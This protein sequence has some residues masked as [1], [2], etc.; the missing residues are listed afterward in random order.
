MG[1]YM[2]KFLSILSVTI[3]LTTST[4]FV[5]CGLFD[6]GSSKKTYSSSR[7]ID[8]TEDLCESVTCVQGETCVV[9][10]DVAQCG[11]FVSNGCDPVCLDPQTCVLAGGQYSCVTPPPT[12][13][14]PACVNPQTCVFAGGQYSCVTPP[15]GCDQTP[16]VYVAGHRHIGNKDVA[17]YWKNNMAGAHELTLSA[18][19][20]YANS[21]SFDGTNLY[22]GTMSYTAPTG[23]SAA[24]VSSA[25]WKNGA[26]TVL[27]PTYSD[28]SKLFINGT[29]VYAAGYHK[30]TVNS[31]TEV[32]AYWL[33]GSKTDL[34]ISAINIY[35]AANQVYVS[36]SDVYACGNYTSRAGYNVAVYWKN[37]T[38]INIG[39]A[40]ANDIYVSGGDIYIA[41]S[42]SPNS[43]QNACYWKNNYRTTLS[44]VDSNAN[45]IFISGSDVY[46]SGSYTSNGKS[47]AC[48]WKNGVKVDLPVP[49]TAQSSY[50]TSIFTHC[51]GVYVSGVYKNS[52][53]NS[54]AT[55]WK[56]STRTDL[57][58]GSQGASARDIHVY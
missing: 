44:S 39:N 56:G 13:C 26:K 32:A 55:F 16:D 2:K 34:P 30:P 45:R 8:T 15:P 5:G 1:G 54:V 23:S 40:T 11:S 49:S 27:T 46:I 25:Y 19:S 29:D 4:I 7:P 12:G 53:G 41:G 9:I 33:N 51:S 10:D 50:T 17:S 14:N 37:E 6:Q 52:S 28:G 58:D 21:I 48:Y 24:I 36:G 42:Y 38:M 22:V 31:D 47:I 57:T 3:F 18:T 20:N 43:I 35:A